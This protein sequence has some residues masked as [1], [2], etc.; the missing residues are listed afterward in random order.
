MASGAFGRVCELAERG[1]IF[2]L[3]RSS[4][5]S[6]WRSRCTK[7]FRL[8]S[9]H[10]CH[11]CRFPGQSHPPHTM[12]PLLPDNATCTLPCPKH[13]RWPPRLPRR[14]VPSAAEA[15]NGSPHTA[16]APQPLCHLQKFL[17]PSIKVK[18]AAPGDA[19][20]GDP[21]QPCSSPGKAAWVPA[22]H[23]G[24]NHSDC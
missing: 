23:S 1:S 19:G 14:G 22:S 17:V 3:L 13:Q 6:S 5:L 9:Q 12:L 21:S 16:P 2:P 20:V 24:V 18:Y 8:Q 15:F 4:N 11:F 10:K 7:S